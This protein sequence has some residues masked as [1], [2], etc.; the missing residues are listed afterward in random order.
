MLKQV[1]KGPR[2]VRILFLSDIRLGT[3]GCQAD[4]LLDFLRHYEADTIYLV[5]D[6]VDGWW[7][8]RLLPR[9]MELPDQ[10]SHDDEDLP[11]FD[12]IHYLIGGLVSPSKSAWRAR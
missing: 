9:L 4:K 1:S 2:Q 8:V 6:I 11:C 7:L 12:V 3:R 5:G 10:Q